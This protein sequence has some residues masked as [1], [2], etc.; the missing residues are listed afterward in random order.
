MFDF[1]LIFI[2]IS[3]RFTYCHG[4]YRQVGVNEG[5]QPDKEAPTSGIN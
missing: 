2:H 1:R 4:V 5:S 3:P